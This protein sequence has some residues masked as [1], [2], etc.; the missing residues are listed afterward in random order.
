MMRPRA[1][2]THVRLA[3]IACSLVAALAACAPASADVFDPLSLASVGAVEQA[4]AADQPAISSDGH[5]VAFWASFGGVSGVWRRDLS[6][7]AIEPVAVGNAETPAGRAELPSISA[8]GRYVS[9]TTSAPLDEANDANAAPDVYVRDMTM[10][11]PP[12]AS[13]EEACSRPCP[14]GEPCGFTLASAFDGSSRALTYLSGSPLYGAIASGRSALSADG[15]HVAFITT[16]TSDLVPAK[17]PADPETPETPP[18]QV[19]VRDLDTR[20]TTLV[21]ALYDPATKGPAIDPATGGDEPVPTW[22]AENRFGAAYTG[23]RA[24]GVPPFISH[25]FSPFVGAAISGDGSTVA[26]SA[27][28]V[29]S[30]VPVMSSEE[31]E[32]EYAEPLWRRVADG[33]RA[34]TRRISGFSDPESPACKAS[35]ET[36]PSRPATL[37]DPCQGP[38][39]A[40]ADTPSIVPTAISDYLP[41]LSADGRTVA[42]LASPPLVGVGEFGT[43]GTSSDDLYIANMRPGLTRVQALRR[44]T[45]IAAGS[46]AA[47][48]RVEPIE[49]VGVSPS[50]TQIAFSSRR[51]VFPLGSPAYVSPPAASSGL[52]EGPQEVYDV[53]LAN[54][55]LTRV[56]QGFA[57][58]PTEQPSSAASTNAAP[59]FG[60][61][62]EEELAFAS[63]ADN[64]VFG[65]GNGAAD[66]FI[67]PRKRF[68][69]ESAAQYISPPPP[70]PAIDPEWVLGVRARSK[71]DG[72]VLLEV[73]VPGAGQLSATAR[74]LLATSAR[75]HARGVSRRRAPRGRSVAA[76]T[77]ASAGGTSRGEGILYVRLMPASRYRPLAAKR[78]GLRATVSVAL[79]APGHRPL[80]RR[81][82]VRFMRAKHSRRAHRASAQS[83][84][85][86]HIAGRAAGS[87]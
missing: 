50:G 86:R 17:P 64:L 76:R 66:V 32:P 48:G 10:S 84:G 4:G 25:D 87:Q 40:G 28:Q 36:E 8:D 7:R 71:R 59:S 67:A 23:S 18:L 63:S 45:A 20:T 72:S 14:P 75:A 51:T 58:G 57:G 5:Y 33:P 3:T 69:D 11:C 83:S 19:A 81:I 79:H 61:G 1:L 53:D 78:G 62:G 46:S 85:A 49:D 2:G 38:F 30:Q 56:T 82:T 16:D 60:G 27:Q 42:F 41:Q 21:S 13:G 24:G 54:D 70:G 9:F 73:S 31:R 12:A 65:D 43:T 44:L 6:S 22:G 34:P 47:T 77:V 55:T 39:E 35:G 52:N 26:W 74:S 80:L 37:A 68:H 15:R 29:A